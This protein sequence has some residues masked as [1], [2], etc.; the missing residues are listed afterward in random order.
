MGDLNA[1][2]KVNW[3]WKA[4]WLG[5]EWGLLEWKCL[6]K[7]ADVRLD[8]RTVLLRLLR[9]SKLVSPIRGV[10]SV[11]QS[12][13]RQSQALKT[14][15]S[16]APWG[17]QLQHTQQQ[18]KSSLYKYDEIYC[19]YIF[20]LIKFDESVWARIDNAGNEPSWEWSNSEFEVRWVT[21]FVFVGE[22]F[23]LFF[24]P[25]C[26]DPWFKAWPRPTLCVTWLQVRRYWSS[27]YF[28]SLMC[29]FALAS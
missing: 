20:L 24:T 19:D 4:G 1:W 7:L 8:S 12:P 29:S 15:G 21:A 5:L 2:A 9:H 25:D 18:Q 14:G 6:S 16:R 26:E 17:T 27:C 23:F 10:T 22:C 11:S 13:G 28:P 3:N